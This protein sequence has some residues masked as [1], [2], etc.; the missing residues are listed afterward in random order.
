MRRKRGKKKV[1]LILS[2]NLINGSPTYALPG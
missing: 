2:Y 1:V